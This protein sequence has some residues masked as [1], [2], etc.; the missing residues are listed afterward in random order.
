LEIP[1]SRIAGLSKLGSFEG[2]TLVRGAGK[3]LV[4]HLD[5]S[6]QFAFTF[7]WLSDL[8]GFYRA[9]AAELKIP[10]PDEDLSED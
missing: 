9:V 4:V 2:G 10:V 1:L 5:D 6:S 8:D 3:K 7:S